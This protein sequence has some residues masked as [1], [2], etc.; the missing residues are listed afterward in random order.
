MAKHDNST[1]RMQN[2]TIDLCIDVAE[3]KPDNILPKSSDYLKQYNWIGQLSRMREPIYKAGHGSDLGIRYVK[4]AVSQSQSYTTDHPHLV[5]VQGNR[6]IR[7]RAKAVAKPANGF[8][9]DAPPA[10]EGWSALFKCLGYK[11]NEDF[12]KQFTLIDD[13]RTNSD[14]FFLLAN[15]FKGAQ[16]AIIL[17][18]CFAL[19][20][21]APD[22]T[23]YSVVWDPQIRVEAEEGFPTLH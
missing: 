13:W 10:Q 20:L 9:C 16:Y 15:R 11:A 21:T 7:W 22:K 3:L 6:M 18:L 4:G 8:G 5:V 17:N 19:T 12:Y 23:E 2:V 1:L 14:S